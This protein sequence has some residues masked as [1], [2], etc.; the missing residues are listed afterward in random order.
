[1]LLNRLEVIKGVNNNLK[2]DELLRYLLKTFIIVYFPIILIATLLFSYYF[3]R[4]LRV[5]LKKAGRDKLVR[6]VGYR[7]FIG[8]FDLMGEKEEENS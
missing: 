7:G 2:I 5:A 6:L 8:I 1:M 3:E 4:V